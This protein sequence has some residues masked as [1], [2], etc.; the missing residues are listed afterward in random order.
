M[1]PYNTIS[2]FCVP[3]STTEVLWPEPETQQYLNQLNSCLTAIR[4]LKSHG[5]TVG[6]DLELLPPA[7][8]REEEL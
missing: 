7:W 4:T 8:A 2:P 1:Q 3:V 5:W 6:C